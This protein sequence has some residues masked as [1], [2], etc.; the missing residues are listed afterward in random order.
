[1]PGTRTFPRDLEFRLVATHRTGRLA[2]KPARGLSDLSTPLLSRLFVMRPS[3]QF[4]QD[5]IAQNKLFEEPDG[6]LDPA[7]VYFDLK[8]AMPGPFI[9][10]RTPACV[11]S[12]IVKS[13]YPSSSQ[14]YIP[15]I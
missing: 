9:G 4:F 12:S 10:P 8:G 6:R 14:R 5:A 13:H 7:A 1:M 3:F 2:A 11:L 15:L